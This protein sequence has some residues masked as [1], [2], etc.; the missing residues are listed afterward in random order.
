MG[1][2][3]FFLSGSICFFF[4]NGRLIISFDRIDNLM[5]VFGFIE[6]SSVSYRS[7]VVQSCGTWM[8]HQDAF[9]EWFT[10]FYWVLLGFTGFYWVLVDFTEFY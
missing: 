1:K 7:L 6:A 4:L 3:S 10:G 9:N 2:A 8:N 5:E